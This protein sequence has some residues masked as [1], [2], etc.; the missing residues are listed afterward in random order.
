MFILCRLGIVDANTF[1]RWRR[2]AIFGLACLAAI[3]SASPDLISFGS[4]AIPLCLLY[5]VGILLCRFVPPAPPEF[6]DTGD[7]ENPLGV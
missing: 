7:E 3:L 4:L 5:E 1:A 6:D 2:Y